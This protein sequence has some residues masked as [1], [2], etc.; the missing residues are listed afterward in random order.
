MKSICFC[1]IQVGFRQVVRQRVL[2]PP[3]GGSNPS[4]PENGGVSTAL[5]KF[6]DY[7]AH[8]MAVDFQLSSWLH[9]TALPSTCF[10]R[11]RRLGYAMPRI[12]KASA[13]T[14]VLLSALLLPVGYAW[15]NLSRKLSRRKS[16]HDLGEA[17]RS[18]AMPCQ[19]SHCQS[20]KSAVRLASLRS[21]QYSDKDLR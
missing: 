4:T 1:Q 13:K 8:C 10:R 3:F 15:R 2:I 21:E 7:R 20:R 9:R 18:L 14:T 17:I 11:S 6:I 5:P 19:Q 16:S 12:C